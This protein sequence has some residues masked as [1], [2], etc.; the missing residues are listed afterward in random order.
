M[1]YRALATDYDGT[2]AK[3]GHVD[4]PTVRALERL[5]DAGYSLIMVTGR[6][7]DE[8][9]A[10]FPRLGMFEMIVAENGAVLYR[11]SSR[12]LKSLAEPPPRSLIAAMQRRGI[13]PIA[14][15]KVVVATWAVHLAAVQGALS[16]VGLNWHTILNKRSLMVLPPG[17]D[18]ATALTVALEELGIS[19]GE[20]VG[21]GDAENDRTFLALCGFSVAVANALPVIRGCVDLVTAGDHGQ[22]MIELVDRLLAGNL[23][24]R[25]RAARPI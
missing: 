6:E 15:G 25:V 20:T 19:A 16:E 17:V 11:P 24:E 8:L 13:D 2:L 5:C 14:V 10:V 7:L 9:G 4:E 12:E 21:V 1:R 23:G 18:K 22:G 3:D